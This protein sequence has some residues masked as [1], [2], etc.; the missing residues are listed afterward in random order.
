[1]RAKDLL[2]QT[3]AEHIAS[4][5]EAKADFMVKDKPVATASQGA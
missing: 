4:A 2:Q 5:G 3:G 1:M